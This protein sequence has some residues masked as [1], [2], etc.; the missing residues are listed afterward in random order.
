[1]LDIG[2][3]WGYAISVRIAI[4]G[5]GRIGGNAAR[6]WSR[7]GHDVVICFSRHPAE[8]GARAA[9]LGGDV[10]AA[11]PADA[12]VD[13]DVVMVA[14]PW[15]AI[16][17]ALE[18]VGSLA[19]KVVLDAT[20]QFG[21][22]PKPAEGQSVAR[23]NSARMPGARYV[24]GFNTLTAGFQAEA[25]GRPGDQRAVLFICGDYP[26][27][28]DIVAKLIDDAGLA[29]VDLGSTEVAQIM[30]APRR[31]GS[32]YGEEYRLPEARAVADAVA[33]GREIPPTPD[34]SQDT[35]TRQ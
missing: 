24:R 4:V 17:Q 18:E 11:A 16:D 25:S 3:V 28:K 30:E 35:E 21:P 6:L 13:A 9:E 1:M 14:V 23:F 10:S 27:A 26:A 8:L 32:V 7:A 29:A 15:S 34:Y 19:G 20:N 31:R 22:G 5:A 33:H 2:A 12:V